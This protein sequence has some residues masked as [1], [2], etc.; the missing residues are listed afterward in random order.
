MPTTT[1]TLSEHDSSVLV[2]R[3]GIPVV[4]HRLVVGPADAPDAADALG[5]PV[6]VKLHGDAVAHKTERGL[7]R[8]HLADRASVEAA[9]ADLLALAR[10]EDEVTGVLV[11][12]VRSG[13]R[14]LVAGMH[15]DPGFGRCV[16]VGIGGV[17]TEA[18]GD[19]AFRL[20][21]LTPAD[22]ADAID[23][24]ELQRLLDP[25]RGEPAVDRDALAAVLLGLSD[26]AQ[27]EPDVVAVDLNPLVVVDG[28][29]IAVDALVEVAG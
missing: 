1:H 2:G 22:A 17:L 27:H 16:M 14:E 7:V 20:A 19:V 6:V 26:L 28:R 4:D 10:P 5:Y 15:V 23:D 3:F 29:P 13:T 25:V 21:P 9:A 12:P 18:V 11:A 24:L 8:L